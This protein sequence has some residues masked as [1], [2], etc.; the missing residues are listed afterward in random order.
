[1]LTGAVSGNAAVAGADRHGW[2]EVKS[3]NEINESF[4]GATG[5]TVSGQNAGSNSLIQQNVNVQSNMDMGSSK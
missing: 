2:T 4:N 1:V 3:K 5:I